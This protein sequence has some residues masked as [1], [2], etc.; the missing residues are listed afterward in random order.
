MW[1]TGSAP[2][3]IPVEPRILGLPGRVDGIVELWK[4]FRESSGVVW[5]GVENSRGFHTFPTVDVEKSPATAQPMAQPL[6]RPP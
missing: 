5:R 6:T 4:A 1:N 3:G 2:A